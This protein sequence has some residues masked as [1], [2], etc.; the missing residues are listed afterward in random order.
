MAEM[1]KMKIKETDERSKRARSI[2]I[3]FLKQGKAVYKKL[4]SGIRLIDF[5]LIQFNGGRLIQ[6]EQDDNISK[7]H[8]EQNKAIERTDLRCREAKKLIFKNRII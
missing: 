3:D 6:L 7:I 1:L 2:L 5:Y 4:Q 8:A